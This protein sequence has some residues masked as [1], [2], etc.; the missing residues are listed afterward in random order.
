MRRDGFLRVFCVLAV[1]AV[2]GVAAAGC[3][4][5]DSAQTNAGAPAGA[6]GSEAGGAAV[7]AGK[8]RPANE[9]EQEQKTYGAEPPP[10]QLQTGERSGYSVSKPSVFVVSSNKELRALQK[11]LKAPGVES[12]VVP[13]D[14]K[15]RQ[16]VAVVFPK[17]P[18]GTL[19]QVTNV[20]EKDG[21]I[22]VTAA[23]ITRGEGCEAGKSTNPFALVETRAMDGR[24]T[25]KLETTQNGACN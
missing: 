5:D 7:E 9:V 1:L 25:L 15:N 19:T 18:P 11:K 6:T 2:F 4:D 13:V 3:G 23:K 20:Q 21:K 8:Q 12:T 24:P 22:V 10:V 14:F 17:S 16:V